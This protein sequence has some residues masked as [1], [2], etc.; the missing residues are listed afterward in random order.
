MKE[1]ELDH[2]LE[3]WQH[4][5]YVYEYASYIAQFDP[6]DYDMEMPT[7]MGE[8]LR[9]LDE[10]LYLKKKMTILAFESAILH[11]R[12]KKFK[13]LCY[14]L[15]AMTQATYLEDETHLPNGVYMLNTYIDLLPGSQNVLVILRNLMGKPVHL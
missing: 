9:D 2:A 5:R 6:E 13:M 11:C 3:S 15:H 7:N 4:A 8:N 10:K 14:W 1:L 12:T